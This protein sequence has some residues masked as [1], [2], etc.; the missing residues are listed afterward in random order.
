MHEI[1]FFATMI[2][3]FSEQKVVV[4][5]REFFR[6]KTKTIQSKIVEEKYIKHVTEMVSIQE[7]NPVCVHFFHHMVRKICN[8]LKDI[9]R[10]SL[11]TSDPHCGEALL[12]LLLAI[13][14]T[15]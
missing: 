1:S 8:T 5:A 7:S 6:R 13:P 15:T 2:C 10:V 12:L 11:S 9:A 4:K 3:F 14:A